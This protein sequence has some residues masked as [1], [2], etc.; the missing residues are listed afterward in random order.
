MNYD[1]LYGVSPNSLIL[2]VPDQYLARFTIL[3][4]RTSYHDKSNDKN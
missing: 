2:R 4:Q 3:Y 1:F